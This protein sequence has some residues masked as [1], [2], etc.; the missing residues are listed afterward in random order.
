MLDQNQQCIS[1]YVNYLSSHS[2]TSLLVP[3]DYIE[4]CSIAQSNTI[5]Q[6]LGT[7]KVHGLFM[8]F[9]A[10]KRNVKYYQ[11]YTLTASAL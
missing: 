4:I 7:Q 2:A 9:V 3:T 11:S 1:P 8:G 5:Y 6:T 10:S